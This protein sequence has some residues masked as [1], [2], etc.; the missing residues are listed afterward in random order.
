MGNPGDKRQCS[1]LDIWINQVLCV[2]H[3]FFFSSRRRHTRFDCDWSSDVCSSDLL[4]PN[5]CTFADNILVGGGSGALVDV[6]RGT[7]LHW[8]GNIVFAGTGGDMPSSGFRGAGER[9]VGGE[10]GDLGGART[11]KKKK[12]YR[13]DRSA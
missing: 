3:L 7:N 11:L 5:E 9:G 4:G 10:G 6:G 13:M 8:Q 2:A 12:K 1:K